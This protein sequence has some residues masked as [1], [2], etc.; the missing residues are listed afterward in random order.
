MSLV[1]FLLFLLL[2]AL[3]I[4]GCDDPRPSPTAEPPAS[5][6]S[7]WSYEG[8]TGP[9]HWA[10][11]SDDYSACDGAQQSPI[12]LT[13]PSDP[14]DGTLL[15]TSYIT[16]SGTVTD[17][18]H[19]VQVNT[20]G[21]TLTLGGTTYDLQQIHAHVPSEHTVAGDRSAAELHLVHEAGEEQL[22]VLGIFVEEGRRAHAALDGWIQGRD[23]T[24]SVNAGRLLPDRQSYYTYEGSLTKPPCREVVRWVVMDHPIQASE[25]Q[26]ETLRAQYGGTARPVQPRGDRRLVYVG[27]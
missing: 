16:E 23:T 5:E 6:S 14:T 1:R 27:L 22:A 13:D 24:L 12:N 11:L 21:G 7:A 18:G 15:N 4:T 25:E 9:E 17:T 2:I 3:A 19:A 20:T 26:I 10:A 8:N